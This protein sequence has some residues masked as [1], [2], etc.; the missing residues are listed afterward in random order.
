MLAAVVS[1]QLAKRA[2][3]RVLDEVEDRPVM[4]ADV[5]A[6]ITSHLIL[7]LGVVV[8]LEGLGFSLGPVGSLLLIVVVVAIL[9]AR[10]G[11]VA[12]SV[13]DGVVVGA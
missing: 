13:G 8:S 11:R 7:V 1:S 3:R 12:R 5:L 10:T 9:A 2:L 4:A 6:R